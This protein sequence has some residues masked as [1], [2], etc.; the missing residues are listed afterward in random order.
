RPKPIPSKIE[1]DEPKATPLED[2]HVVKRNSG[3][4]SQIEKSVLYKR[5]REAFE[6]F[7]ILEFEGGYELASSTYDALVSACI[8]LKSIR[9]VKR[10][11]NYMISNGFEP[12]QYMRN[13]VL[14]MHVKCGMMIDARRLF[15]EMPERNLVSWNTIIGGLVDSGDFMD[16]FQ[17]FLVMWQ[18]FSD[19]GSR[20]FA[21]MIR[22]SAGLGLVFAGRQF[23]SCCLK[24]GLGADIFISCALIDMYSKCGNIEDAQC[25]FDEMPR[26]TTVGWN[27]IIAGYAL[28]G[29]SEE[30]LSMYY[31]MRDSGVR[32]D[33][34]TF[35]MIIRICAR[36]ASLEHAKQA[37][38]GLVRHG[39][40]L[41]VVANTSLVDFYCK[42]G[43]IE[44]ARHVFDQMP[45]KNVISWNALIAGYGN[46]GRGDEAVEMF[47]KM[48]QEGMVP[49]HV[50]FLAVLSACSHSG[51]SERGWEI[52]ESMSRDHKIKPRA[53][54][55][56]CMIELLGREGLLDEASAL[57]RSAPFNPTANMWAALLT[58]C[59]VHENLELGK[60]AAEKLYGM[61]P[62]KLSNYV[63]L[64][65]IYSSSG[66][67][68]EAASVVQTLRRKGLRMLPACSWIEVKKHLHIFHSGDK[69][70]SET[71]EIYQKMDDLMIRI[72]K[73]GYIPEEKH[74]L[75]DVDEH[76]R[77]LFY[78]S[79]KLAIAYGLI[80]TADGTPLQIVQSHRI[81]GD[82]HSAVKLIARVT[83]RE[84]VVRDA[85]RFHHFKDGSC[86]CG[87]YW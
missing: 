73:H 7:E 58:A 43:R 64:L 5:Y 28:H 54:H 21:T 83:G 30:A 76:E 10:V 9:G 39:F 50:T 47:E 38:A 70:H 55:Y 72:T 24:M 13:R 35:S 23:H 49:N 81:C 32:M 53:M 68:K 18:E 19:G 48:L 26:K 82:C 52:F 34:F 62:E 17:L 66:K 59:R 31:D 69:S 11:T 51:L 2:T 41:D 36:L 86:S 22:A 12:D 25:V 61:E 78:H 60:F 8:S 40:G 75:P 4:C 37:H 46:H 74:L 15:E 16:A 6:L 44:D 14:L 57:I 63:V 27:S 67:L 77:R 71:R 29:Y 80:S 79:E 56:A 3:L 20:T 45:L 85:S 33:H 65:N 84:I 1:V 42:W 87:N